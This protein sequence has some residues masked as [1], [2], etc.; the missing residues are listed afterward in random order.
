MDV[1][2]FF[3]GGGGGG[4]CFHLLCLLRDNVPRFR[5]K[6]NGGQ[7]DGLCIGCRGDEANLKLAMKHC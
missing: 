5:Q 4:E 1:S 7:G 2:P 3:S 6:G